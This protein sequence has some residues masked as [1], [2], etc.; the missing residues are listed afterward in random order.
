[1][2][3]E[4]RWDL[5]KIMSAKAERCNKSLNRNIAMLIVV[6]LLGFLVHFHR[7]PS[8]E[9]LSLE[10][11][12]FGGKIAVPKPIVM[13]CIPLLASVI[14]IRMSSLVLWTMAY[15]DRLREKLREPSY[16]DPAQGMTE[17]LRGVSI[18]DQVLLYENEFWFPSHGLVWHLYHRISGIIGHR[19]Q[20]GFLRYSRFSIRVILKQLLSVQQ[21]AFWTMSALLP[22][23]CLFFLVTKVYPMV[24]LSMAIAVSIFAGLIACVGVSQLC[25]GRILIWRAQRVERS[26]WYERFW[27]SR[28]ASME[29]EAKERIKQRMMGEQRLLKADLNM[30]KQEFSDLEEREIGED[31]KDTYESM[32]LGPL[33]SRIKDKERQLV[34]QDRQLEKLGREIRCLELI[35]KPFPSSE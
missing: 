27:A 32:I 22:I 33:R 13:V 19:R 23:P 18:D 11:S 2:K 7:A 31:L 14:Y 15:R 20:P 34:M 29:L 3:E 1:M 24:S 30:L 4:M 25:I 35:G 8:Q 21:L 9:G 16:G 5:W 28:A 17:Q 26:V 6:I 12:L 10:L